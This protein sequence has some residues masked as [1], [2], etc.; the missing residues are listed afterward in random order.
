MPRCPFASSQRVQAAAVVGPNDVGSIGPSASSAPWGKRAAHGVEFSE[1]L[2]GRRLAAGGVLLEHAERSQQG[3]RQARRGVECGHRMHGGDV[4]AGGPIDGVGERGGRAG[5][6]E[7]HRRGDVVGELQCAGLGEPEPCEHREATHHPARSEPGPVVVAA[8]DRVGH[9]PGRQSQ[10]AHEVDHQRQVDQRPPV[11]HLDEVAFGRQRRVESP[12]VVEQLRRAVGD[13][14]G[15]EQRG[16]VGEDLAMVGDRER[17]VA[18]AAMRSPAGSGPTSTWCRRRPTR[19]PS[20]RRRTHCAP[21]AGARRVDPARPGAARRGARGRPAAG[22]G[23]VRPGVIH[24]RAHRRG[25]SIHSTRSSCQ[26]ASL[27]ATPATTAGTICMINTSARATLSSADARTSRTAALNPFGSLASTSSTVVY[28]PAF[29]VV[30]PSSDENAERTATLPRSAV[31]GLGGGIGWE[32]PRL[33]H[34]KA[35][36]DGSIEQRSL[37]SDPLGRQQTRADPERC[38]TTG[39]QSLGPVGDRVRV[40]SGPLDHRE[41][42]P[43]RHHVGPRLGQQRPVVGDLIGTQHPVV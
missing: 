39:D 3:R 7:C 33:R 40:V 10:R 16:R 21:R 30:T 28:R 5:V 17:L 11:E 42:A 8:A 35:T 29:D 6:V 19:C 31:G 18:Q 34:G 4:V 37:R 38:R 24:R 15:H 25:P 41:V 9:E 13:Q 23:R 20:V 27:K 32:H 36:G 26:P 12:V 22:V 43:A 14:R 2:R 1:H